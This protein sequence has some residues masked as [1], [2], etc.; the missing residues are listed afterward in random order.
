MALCTFKRVFC[1]IYIP[2]KGISQGISIEWKFLS[3]AVIRFM[4]LGNKVILKSR[5]SFKISSGHGSRKSRYIT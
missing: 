3:D 4:Y 1:I 5:T 2:F